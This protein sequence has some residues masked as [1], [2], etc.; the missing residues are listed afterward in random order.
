MIRDSSN[1]VIDSDFTYEFVDET[2][3]GDFATAKDMMPVTTT[4]YTDSAGDTVY[5]THFGN[6]P[7]GTLTQC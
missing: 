5:L 2:C 6:Y 1:V 3:G 4:E 7:V